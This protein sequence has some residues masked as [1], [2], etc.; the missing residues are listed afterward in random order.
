MPPKI[1]NISE[2][3]WMLILS[4]YFEIH[5]CKIKLEH[6]DE[7]QNEL[8]IYFSQPV[9][10]ASLFESH[11]MIYDHCNDQTNQTTSF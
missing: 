3:K 7:V 11:H 4:E 2:I 5:T 9:V 10:E 1:L 6:W 8:R